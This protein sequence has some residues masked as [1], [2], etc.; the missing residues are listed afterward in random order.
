MKL[1]SWFMIYEIVYWLGLILIIIGSIFGE[2]IKTNLGYN[3]ITV[4]SG[5]V[6]AGYAFLNQRIIKLEIRRS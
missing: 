6:V 3:N 5:L 1:E 4:L 2:W